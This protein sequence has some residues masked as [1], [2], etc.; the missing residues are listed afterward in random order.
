M[1]FELFIPSM[2]KEFIG[3]IF[4]VTHI[5]KQCGNTKLKKDTNRIFKTLMNLNLNPLQICV[6]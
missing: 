3:N 2:Y 6:C 1:I 5:K 4:L